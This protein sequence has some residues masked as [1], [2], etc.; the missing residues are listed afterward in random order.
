[1]IPDII[2]TSAAIDPGSFFIITNDIIQASYSILLMY[3]ISIFLVF[4]EK[5]GYYYYLISFGIA[6]QLID[7][8][9]M[10]NTGIYI[11]NDYVENK[12]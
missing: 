3:I 12:I 10:L 9:I 6:L 5:I 8:L 2:A 11:R 4:D 1:M 7:I